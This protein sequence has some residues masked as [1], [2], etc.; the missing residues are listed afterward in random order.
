M[1]IPEKS[2]YLGLVHRNFAEEIVDWVCKLPLNLFLYPSLPCPYIF[3]SPLSTHFSF[4]FQSPPLFHLL[5]PPII[6]LLLYNIII[7]TDNLR[8]IIPVIISIFV[9]FTNSI[10]IYL[11]SVFIPPPISSISFPSFLHIQLLLPLSWLS[12]S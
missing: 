2:Q 4:H 7:L 1:M 5:V 9:F 10:Y 3:S 8:I 12:L 6:H 11:F